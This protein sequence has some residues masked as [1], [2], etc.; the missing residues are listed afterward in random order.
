MT[1][2][3]GAP[4]A[5]RRA[6]DPS[7][8]VTP[9]VTGQAIAGHRSELDGVRAIAVLFVIAFHLGLFVFRSSRFSSLLLGVDA[10]FVLSG[11]L[12]TT[13][14][15]NEARR[16][17][18]VDF[19]AFYARRALRLLPALG[20]VLVLAGFFSWRLG[21]WMPQAGRSFPMSALLTLLYV[22][23]WFVP[24]GGLNLL[25][26]TWSLAIEEQYYL[27]WPAVLVLFLRRSRSLRVMGGATVTAALAV[28]GVRWLLAITG[29]E[30]VAYNWTISRADGVLLGSG[31]AL[32][33]HAG[34]PRL[35][36]LLRRVWC[37][38]MGCISVVCA[39]VVWSLSTPTVAPVT[40][41]LWVSVL[42]CCSIA[43]L[44]G[45][46]LVI[47]HL[48]VARGSP[49]GRPLRLR[50][51]AGIG[52]I[53]YGLY[54]YHYPVARWVA[55]QGL[56]KAAAAALTVGLSF[57]IAGSSYAAIERPALRLKARFRPAS[58][59]PAAG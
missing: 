35:E 29:H 20:V 43:Y 6:D 17:G 5:D 41:V 58:T 55:E 23:N 36:T 24:Y 39:L 32:L 40:G 9:V 22:G 11:Y 30:L 28:I 56:P 12:I 16:F 33:L 2:S 38:V 18:G 10:F 25:G 4:Q 14:L 54:L 51:V 50:P 26:H 27:V 42:T 37:G 7:S 13:L 52:R 31:L 1:N 19:K 21:M 44:V 47:G 15:L 34:S 3:S 59:A 57:A 49:L 8:A 45:V 48:V 46:W 53:S